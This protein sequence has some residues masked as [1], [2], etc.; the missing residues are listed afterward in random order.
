MK[1]VE[2]IKTIVREEIAKLHQF[3]QD[4]DLEDLKDDALL[5][6]EFGGK[7]GLDSLDGLDLILAMQKAFGVELDEATVDWSEFTTIERI[8][9]LIHRRSQENI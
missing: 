4:F 3:E 9:S 6:D 2:E 5:F 8:A 7:L 1:T